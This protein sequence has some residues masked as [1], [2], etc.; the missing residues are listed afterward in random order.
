MIAEVNP[1]GTMHKHNILMIQIN[2]II[3]NYNLS[4]IIK[5]IKFSGTLLEILI[6]SIQSGV[7]VVNNKIHVCDNGLELKESKKQKY[8]S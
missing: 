2:S 8:I 4:Q 3:T 5:H 6:H 1:I 7:L